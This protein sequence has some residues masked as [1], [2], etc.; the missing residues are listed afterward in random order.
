[1]ALRCHSSV[2]E[3]IDPRQS[4]QTKRVHQFYIS[5]GL[6]YRYLILIVTKSYRALQKPVTFKVSLTRN[7]MLIL[8][9]I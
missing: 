9:A 6:D 8:C 7:L 5:F 2:S 4:A 3:P 1:M